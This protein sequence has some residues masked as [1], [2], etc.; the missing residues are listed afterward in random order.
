M[1]LQRPGYTESTLL[2]T[3]YLQ[4]LNSDK[5]SHVIDRS[6][7]RFTNWLYTTSGFYDKSITGTYFDFNSQDIL[8]SECFIKFI[9]EYEKSIFGCDKLNFLVHKIVDIEIIHAYCSLFNANDYT[10]FWFNYKKWYKILENKSVLLINSFAPLMAQQYESGNLHKIDTNFPNFTNIFSYRTPYTFFNNGPHNNFFETLNEMVASIKK[11]PFDVAIIGCGAYGCLIADAIHKNNI[12]ICIGS[13][14]SQMFGVDPDMRD[15]HLW[16][17]S[18]P[19][20]Y[21]PD[22]YQ[23][24]ENGRYWTGK[25]HPKIQA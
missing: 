24:I 17:S 13:R 11:I 18:I 8:N 23:K 15:N 5:Y 2:V 12:V 21:I 1:K 25:H 20:E 16:I 9:N 19:S 10:E 7:H 6:L 22:N 14:A 4:T 3:K